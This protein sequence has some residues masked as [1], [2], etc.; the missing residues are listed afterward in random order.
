VLTPKIATVAARLLDGARDRVKADSNRT[1]AIL[2][3][4]RVGDRRRRGEERKGKT[5]SLSK[6]VEEEQEE[7][8]AVNPCAFLSPSQIPEE[9]ESV[10]LFAWIC[11]TGT[12]CF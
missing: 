9:R 8:E 11:D 10:G 6:Q 5:K 7:K 12:N 1:A 3:T 4:L 2:T